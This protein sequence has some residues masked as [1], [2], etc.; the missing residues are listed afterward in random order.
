MKVTKKQLFV[1]IG[2]AVLSAATLIGYQIY[3]LKQFTLTPNGVQFKTVS[4]KELNFD[5]YLNFKNE[6]TLQIALAYQKYKVYINNKLITTITTN[7]PQVILPKAVSVLK[8]NVVLS[9]NEIIKKLGA[10][11]LLNIVTFKQQML[12]I[13]VVAGIKFGNF[14]IPITKTIEDKIVN[15]ASP[16]K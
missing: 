16:S 10:S 15:W 8:A 13:D 12:R 14:V 11:S 2:L 4:M 5:A 3:K 7:V 6:S 9:P 1:G